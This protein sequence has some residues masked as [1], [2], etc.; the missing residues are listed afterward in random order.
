MTFLN[1]AMLAGLTAMAV[2]VLIHLISRGRAKIV[3]WGAMRFLLA[4]LALRNRRIML[5]EIILLAVR[6]L[7]LAL[8]ALAMAR[9]F[10][11]SGSSVSWALVLPAA[12]AAAFSLAVG[13]AMW[14]HRR[15]RWSCYGLA[16]VFLAAS[17]LAAAVEHLRQGS[18]WPKQA[19]QQDI[20]IVIDASMSMGLSVAGQA[21]FDRAVEEARSV[22]A[23]AGPGDGVSLILA[24]PMPRAVIAAPTVDREEIT[25]ALAGLK[26]PTGGAMAVPEALS[27]AAAS[28]AEGNNLE[29]KVILITTI[30]NVN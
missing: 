19:G 23:A 22:I 29:K 27:A 15:V 16:A 18:L 1:W 9:P 24:G 3:D 14:S 20:A 4:S 5:E 7:T 2:P 11:P 21:N 25:A 12:L 8:L 30:G 13:T 26:E 6:C 28:L 17:G 10:L